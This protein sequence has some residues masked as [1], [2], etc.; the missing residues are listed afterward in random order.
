MSFLKAT[1]GEKEFELIV[2]PEEYKKCK[3]KLKEGGCYLVE[4]SLQKKYHQI[5]F[6]LKEVLEE[7]TFWFY[8]N[9]IM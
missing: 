2:F 6:I 5:Q 8:I 4:L 7:I 3:K 9:Y 1:N